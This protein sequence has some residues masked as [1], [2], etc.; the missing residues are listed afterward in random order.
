MNRLSGQMY[1]LKYT[2]VEFGP[3]HDIQGQMYLYTVTVYRWLT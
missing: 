2:P 1:I 3:V